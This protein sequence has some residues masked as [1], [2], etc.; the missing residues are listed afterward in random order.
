MRNKWKHGQ[1]K[2]LADL[3]GIS[4][5]YM[6]DVLHGRHRAT[7]ELA[8]KIEES[9]TQLGLQISRFDVMYPNESINPLIASPNRIIQG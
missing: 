9:A 8:K 6:S 5:S 7:P 4:K 3:C 1:K 2:Q